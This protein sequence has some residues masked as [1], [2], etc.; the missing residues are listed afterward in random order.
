[1]A[2]F[3][4]KGKMVDELKEMSLEDFSKL[5]NARQRR[6]LKRGLTPKQKKFLEKIR[7][8]KDRE[9]V[10]RTHC[11]DMIILPEMVGLKIGVHN[12]QEF[13]VINITENML[14]HVL[15]EF[16]LTRKQVK[17]S[18]PGFGATRSSK[19]VPLK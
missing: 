18:S 4:F 14:G 15:G 16:A 7:K 8:L 9:K 2:K 6:S 5:L 10:I 19:F 1:M 12:G 13:K 11:R 17:H 3:L